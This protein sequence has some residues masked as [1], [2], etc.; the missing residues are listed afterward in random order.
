MLRA[1]SLV[2][3]LVL[4]GCGGRWATKPPPPLVTPC[5]ERPAAHIPDEPEAP[6]AGEPIPDTYV[7]DLKAWANELLGVIVADRI[8]WRSERRCVS[9]IAEAGHIQ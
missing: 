3:V 4:A 8:T 6:P 7:R 9:R 5:L 2:L 1:T